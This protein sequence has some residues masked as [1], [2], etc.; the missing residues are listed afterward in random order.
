M[1][2]KQTE[3]VRRLRRK[4][5]V[6]VAKDLFAFCV[7]FVKAGSTPGA[8]NSLAMCYRPLSKAVKCKSNA[9]S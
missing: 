4:F 2:D 7:S 5:L 8:G 1:P 3:A 6:L 9:G